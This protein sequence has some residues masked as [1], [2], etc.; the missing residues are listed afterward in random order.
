MPALVLLLGLASNAFLLRFVP[1][2]V[3]PSPLP[4]EARG[5]PESAAEA[6]REPAVPEAVNVT[7][8]RAA[9]AIV[10]DDLGWG[11][12]GTREALGLPP[13]VSLAVLPHGPKSTQEARE[14]VTLGH[15]VLLHL[16]MEPL[17]SLP[18][19]GS[20]D[21]YFVTVDMPEERIEQLVEEYARL[22]PGAIAINNHMGSRASTDDRVVR[23]VVRAASRLGLGVLD[24]KT[25]AGSKLFSVALQA[26]LKAGQNELFIDNLKER[27]HVRGKLF[28]AARIALKKQR[29]VIVIGHVHPV[30]VKA[31]AETWLELKQ[32][33]VDLVKLSQALDTRK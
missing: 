14:A 22:V 8:T 28:Q 21:K 31:I 25:I 3:T 4:Q 7:S 9:L 27:D 13:E 32:M 23:A 29:P 6:P 10:L 19:T 16:P 15:E 26:G 1:P 2:A 17:G 5:T 30:T 20:G 12:S 24:S 11:V 18:A 33:G